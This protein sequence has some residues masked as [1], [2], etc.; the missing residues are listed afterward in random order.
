MATVINTP[1]A[2]APVGPY[3][4]AV[5]CGNT[6]YCSG[7][8]ALHPDTGV[9]V[10]QAEG[11]IRAEVRQVLNNLV[12]VLAAAGVQPSRV[13]RTTVYLTDL[14]QFEVVNRIYADV[15]G[16]EVS[17]ARSCVQVAALPKGATVEIDAVAVVDE[18]V[19]E[20]A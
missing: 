20:Q 6:I 9:V 11:D 3:S 4:Q 7:Q 16:G 10:G 15:F 1:T 13:V 2:P 18:Q 12:A 8:I 17:P 5:R 19:D 14:S